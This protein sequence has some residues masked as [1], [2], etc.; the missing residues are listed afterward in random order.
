MDDKHI[1][2]CKFF[3]LQQS[4]KKMK[5]IGIALILF[6]LVFSACSEEEQKKI[7]QTK[8]KE[9]EVKMETFEKAESYKKTIVTAHPYEK[10]SAD[11]NLV[12]CASF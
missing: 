6:T 1:D 9:E 3:N 4:F 5:K 2:K 12:Y 7:A 11:K 10:I 8:E